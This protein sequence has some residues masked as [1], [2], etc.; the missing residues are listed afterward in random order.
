MNNSVV[1][2]QWIKSFGLMWLW[3]CY[4]YLILVDIIASIYKVL[5]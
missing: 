2:S 3:I 4:S 1:L 5:T